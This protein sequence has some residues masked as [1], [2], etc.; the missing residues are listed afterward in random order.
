[1]SHTLVSNHAP[2]SRTIYNKNTHK[3]QD[4]RVGE[5]YTAALSNEPSPGR[6]GQS[7]LVASLTQ[8]ANILHRGPLR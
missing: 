5:I 3:R 1:M 2:E 8:G 6:A 7:I 4:I